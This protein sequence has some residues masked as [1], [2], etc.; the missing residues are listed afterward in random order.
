MAAGDAV[1]FNLAVKNEETHRRIRRNK[2]GRIKKTRKDDYPPAAFV[3]HV[4]YRLSGHFRRCKLAVTVIYSTILQRPRTSGLT[5]KSGKALLVENYSGVGRRLNGA[6]RE[7]KRQNYGE[8]E[9][10][11]FSRNPQ[12]IADKFSDERAAAARTSS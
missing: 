4:E 12:R 11:R 8:V 10:Q 2:F 1:V 6:S 7:D 9:L 3:N 5:E